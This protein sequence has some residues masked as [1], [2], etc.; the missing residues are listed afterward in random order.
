MSSA[1]ATATDTH[2]SL[3]VSKCAVVAAAAAAAHHGPR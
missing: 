1:L 2:D 3:A